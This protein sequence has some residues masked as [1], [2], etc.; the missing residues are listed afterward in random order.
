MSSVIITLQGQILPEPMDLEVPADVPV[1]RL[2]P[3]LVNALG[4]PDGDYYLE[5]RTRRLSDDETL[6]AAEVY[7]GDALTL[8]RAQQ[9][10]EL[11]GSGE[12]TIRK[13]GRGGGFLRGLVASAADEQVTHRRG[14]P[15]PMRTAGEAKGGD[16]HLSDLI[17]SRAPKRAAATSAT[18]IAFWSGPAGG[19]GRTILA[20]ALAIQAAEQGTDT[21][22]L[23][24]SEPAISAYL[25]LPRVPNVTTF[26][27]M[28]NLKA[29]EQA[30]AWGGEEDRAS[31]RVML[32]PARPRD[33]VVED[34]QIGALVS[35]SCAMHSLV[36]VD[37]PALTPGGNAWAVEPL[38]KVDSVMLV[39]VPSA[40]GVAATVEALATLRDLRAFARPY[41]IL[42]RRSRAGLA[43]QAFADG[44]AQLWGS[45]PEIVLE[46]GYLADLPDVVDR[47]ELADAVAGPSPLANAMGAL[48]RFMLEDDT[49]DTPSQTTVA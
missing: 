8:R 37:V 35:A 9:G 11:A 49:P 39:M 41:L 28:G 31:M 33:G 22:L 14:E 23:A 38:T 34:G 5:S 4:L 48:A 42:N 2:L 20:L 12:V 43:Q 30:L 18:S 21:V 40:A 15:P 27:E 45:C 25:R 7:T 19:T 29:A 13:V 3:E 17:P 10:P 24:L 36:V 1:G 16:I 6:S 32:G 26:L 44:V 47:G 46:I